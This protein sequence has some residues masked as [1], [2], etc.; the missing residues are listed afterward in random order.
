MA[1][2]YDIAERI[3]SGNQRPTVIVDAEHEYKINN[4]KSIS[5]KIQAMVEESEKEN[6]DEIDL[7]NKIVTLGLGK[8]AFDYIESLDLPI[9]NWNDVVNV[10]M[11]A[12]VGITLEEI[13]E[14]EEETQKGE[15][16]GKKVK[17]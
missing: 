4:G 11:A 3:A 9:S 7:I 13:E 12:S 5:L 15:K 14:K 1:R 2:K 6:T 10:I 17:K 8:E 16:S